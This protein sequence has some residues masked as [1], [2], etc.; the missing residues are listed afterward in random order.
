M[1][2]IAVKNN[3]LQQI[4][5]K[6]FVVYI[7]AGFPN[8][9]T[10]EQLIPVLEKN[11]VD[12]IE[13]GMPFSDPIAD[14][15]TIQKSSYTA[16]QKGMNLE[17]FFKLVC[18][19]RKKSNIPLIMMTYYNPIY[20]YGIKRFAKIAHQSGLD[21]VI[22]PDLPIEEASELNQCLKQFD[23]ANIFLVSPVTPKK[24]IRKIAA[25]SSGFIYY[26][27]LTGV[28]GVRD[29]LPSD[30]VQNIKK[31]KSVTKKPVFVGFGVSKPKQIKNIDRAASGVIVGSAIIKSIATHYGT[32]NFLKKIG[33]FVASLSIVTK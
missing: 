9:K 11:G 33:K 20:N 26:V 7:T 32:K 16:L 31:I 10:T 19:I 5:K 2:R 14:G 23:I 12:F 15:P 13:L 25:L 21:G 4:Q 8:I 24:R 29:K 30:L 22:V 3:H 27:S 28:T 17:K 6:A 1:N 18:S